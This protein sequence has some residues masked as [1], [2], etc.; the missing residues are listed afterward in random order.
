MAHAHGNCKN[1][2]A[3]AFGI[4]NAGGEIEVKPATFHD[5]LGDKGQPPQDSASPAAAGGGGRQPP[6]ASPSATS[7]LGSGE[8][9]VLLVIV[10]ILV[11]IILFILFRGIFES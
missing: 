7:D 10:L 4:N 1:S 11:L 6:D 8:K 2:R 3:A 9:N 5:F